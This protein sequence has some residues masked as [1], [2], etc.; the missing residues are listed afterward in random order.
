MAAE[1]DPDADETGTNDPDPAEGDLDTSELTRVADL[2]AFE[3][4][5][6]IIVDVEGR[7]IAVF[8]VDGEFHAVSN[9]CV[10]QGGPVCEGMLSGGLSVEDPANADDRAELDY[11][12]ADRLVSCPWHGWEFDVVTGE[13]LARPK[14]RLPTYDVVVDDGA[15]YLDA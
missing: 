8:A 14:Y 15:V 11:S 4:V 7:E 2:D 3:D 6:R 9:Y 1:D 5:D 10:H 13:H 12:Y